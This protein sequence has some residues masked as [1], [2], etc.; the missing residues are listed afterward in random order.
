[1]ANESSLSPGTGER[2]GERGDGIK[3]YFSHSNIS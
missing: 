2:A 1:M 3:S